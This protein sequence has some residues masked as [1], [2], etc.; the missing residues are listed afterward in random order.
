MPFSSTEIYNQEG[1]IEPILL[2]MRIRAS[3]FFPLH[4]YNFK[5]NPLKFFKKY[6]GYKLPQKKKDIPHL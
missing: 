6:L 3:K 1:R 2:R 4:S 5:I